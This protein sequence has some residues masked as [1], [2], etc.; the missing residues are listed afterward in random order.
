MARHL[1]TYRIFD[2]TRNFEFINGLAIPLVWLCGNFLNDSDIKLG[3]YS[4]LYQF[5]IL[6]TRNS[7]S[8][9]ALF[10]AIFLASC[11]HH[12]FVLKLYHL[13]SIHLCLD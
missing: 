10:G 11:V 2:I 3:T 5:V 12:D 9:K 6:S 4:T 1:T 7:N 8:N 13:S